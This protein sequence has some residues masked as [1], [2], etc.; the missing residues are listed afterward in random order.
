MTGAKIIRL[1]ARG[2][3]DQAM[4]RLEIDPA[5]FAPPPEEQYWSS[6]TPTD[7]QEAIG[8]CP[9]DEFMMILKGRVAT[10]DGAGSETVVKAGEVFA[11]TNGA[12]VSWKQVGPCRK[13]FLI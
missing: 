13:F 5:A 4:E 1:E 11:V 7:M 3:P 9:G 10:L 6:K 12:S 2:P 8:P